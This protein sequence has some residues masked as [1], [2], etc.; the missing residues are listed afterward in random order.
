L[1]ALELLSGDAQTFRAKVWASRVHLHQTDPELLVGLLSLD[2]VDRLLTSSAIRTPAVRLAQDGAVLP[3][4]RFTRS[5]SQAGQPMTISLLHSHAAP[6]PAASQRGRFPAFLHSRRS[7][8]LT[9]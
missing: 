9:A 3:T 4:S 8:R 5:A 7:G 6:H 1:S 2:D